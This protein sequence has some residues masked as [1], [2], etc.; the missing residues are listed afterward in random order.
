MLEVAALRM[1]Q[2]RGLFGT[3][4]GVVVGL[5]EGVAV[6]VGLCD[7]EGLG[8]GSTANAPPAGKIAMATAAAVNPKIRMF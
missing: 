8:V 5:T 4:V 2:E 3:G 7:C 6:V 1:L